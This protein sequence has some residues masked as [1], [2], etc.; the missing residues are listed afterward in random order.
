MFEV[1]M[2]LE[3]AVLEKILPMLTPESLAALS[4]MVEEERIAFRTGNKERWVKLSAEFHI[5]LARLTG[6]ETLVSAITKYVTRT[7]LLI[8][9]S[10]P[11]T[12]GS[13]SFD[14]HLEILEAIRRKDLSAAVGVMRS[15]LAHCERRTPVQSQRVDLRAV[16]GAGVGSAV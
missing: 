9:S 10:H 12:A 11:V 14:E 4:A 2:I 13:C 8:S 1:R 16:L 3:A 7:T 6:N 5:A 15:H